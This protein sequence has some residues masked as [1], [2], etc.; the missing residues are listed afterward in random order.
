MYML[1]YFRHRNYKPFKRMRTMTMNHVSVDP[2][3]TLIPTHH[4]IVPPLD[5]DGVNQP[6]G[7]VKS[8]T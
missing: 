5:G 2:K 7:G 3:V 6:V 8:V 4:E 1:G